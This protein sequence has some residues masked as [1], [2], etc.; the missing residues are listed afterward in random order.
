M[1]ERCPEELSNRFVSMTFD[2]FTKNLV[3]RF[4][5]ALPERHRPSK[6]YE[7]SFPTFRQEKS[8][9]SSFRNNFG[10]A[11]G[12]YNIMQRLQKHES[13]YR[14]CAD[15]RLRIVMVGGGVFR[16]LV[17]PADKFTLTVFPECHFWR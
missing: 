16:F 11:V 9:I 2:A 17:K 7:I 15:R 14:E 13:V 3:D 5:M 1:K 12:I 10:N 6:R 8:L 4:R